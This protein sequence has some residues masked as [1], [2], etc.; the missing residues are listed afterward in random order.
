MQSYIVI[1]YFADNIF[2]SCLVCRRTAVSAQSVIRKVLYTIELRCVLYMCLS[3]FT[4]H[5]Y[6]VLVLFLI[7]YR[8]HTGKIYIEKC[9]NQKF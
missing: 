4:L 8:I 6:K 3:S 5:V 7:Q 1:V 9:L 2:K